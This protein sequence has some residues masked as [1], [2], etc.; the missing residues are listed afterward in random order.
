[1]YICWKWLQSSSKYTKKVLNIPNFLWET[2]SEI[3]F[4][5]SFSAAFRIRNNNP[6]MNWRHDIKTS[7]ALPCPYTLTPF[8]FYRYLQM[9]KI[10]GTI[11][12]PMPCLCQTYSIEP[13]GRIKAQQSHLQQ[14]RCTRLCRLE[15]SSGML[16]TKK[17]WQWS[18]GTAH[19]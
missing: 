6:M 9:R 11:Q 5:F 10:G 3:H 13:Q 15:L 17:R 12:T 19:I 16:T 4:H 1:M 14:A 18:S 2:L 8:H 7:Q